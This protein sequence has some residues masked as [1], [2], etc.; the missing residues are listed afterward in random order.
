MAACARSRTRSRSPPST[1]TPPAA[2]APSGAESCIEAV[3][4]TLTCP[5]GAT[6]RGAL[7]KDQ[8]ELVTSAGPYVRAELALAPRLLAAAGVRADAVR[9]QVKDRP[10]SDTNPDDSGDRT[11]HA[12][13]PALGVVWRAAPLAS[14]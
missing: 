1:W 7:R 4:T 11:L 10:V 14:M 12:V 13:S 8:R 2:D 3:A 9:F 6:L 5:T